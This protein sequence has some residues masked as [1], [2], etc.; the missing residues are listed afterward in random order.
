MEAPDKVRESAGLSSAANVDS[1]EPPTLPAKRV[2][3]G[4]TCGICFEDDPDLLTAG[5]ACGHRYCTTCYDQYLKQKIWDEGESR[6]IRC[7]AEKCNMIVD[8]KMVGQIV[9]A[10]TKER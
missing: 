4:F 10:S 8:Q 1:D 2:R 6:R 7:P 5:L 9:D 3:K